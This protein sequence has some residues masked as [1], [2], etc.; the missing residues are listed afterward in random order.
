MS[1]R[2]ALVLDLTADT[3]IADQLRK[4]SDL[5]ARL[6]ALSLPII[7]LTSAGTALKQTIAQAEKLGAEKV[8][9]VSGDQVFLDPSVVENGL[10]RFASQPWDYLTQWEHVRLPVGVGFRA[11]A[12]SLLKR[13]EADGIDGF[14]QMAQWLGHNRM[15]VVA[16][17]DDHTYVPF[18]AS[19][20]D[21]R[22]RPALKDL[23]DADAHQGNWSLAGALALGRKAGAALTYARAPSGP[24]PAAVDGRGMP[25]LYGFESDDCG[26]FPTY[27]MLDITNRC[28]AACI[29]CPQ[30]VGFPG[31][32]NTTF[33]SLE[34]IKA[35]LDECEGRPVDFLRI[36]ADGEP[37]LHPGIYDIIAMATRT[38]IKSVGLTTNG[39]A[40]N[41]ANSA[42]LL[43]AG[44][45]VVDVS[46]DAASPESFAK[47]RVGLSYERTIENLKT[48]IRMRDE[49][50]HPLKIMVSFVKQPD[51]AHEEDAF[52]KMW[53]P[54]VD[55][56]LFRDFH[57]NVN[58]TPE[59]KAEAEAA[60]TFRW[61]CPHVFRRTVLGYDDGLKFCP[62]DWRGGSVL[63]QYGTE[64]LEAFWQGDAYHALRMV[65]L[66]N[67][68]SKDSYCGPC[69]DW[70]ATPWSLGYEKVISRLRA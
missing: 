65:H 64:P 13:A 24:Q 46:L 20:T 39:S 22:A 54:V 38:N 56:V 42:R 67:S 45:H 47:I 57:T 23:V 43:D 59:A 8:V 28:N 6:A 53:E 40:M 63:Q 34:K 21:T 19:L 9:V 69:G 11:Y 62:I 5:E 17:Y 27:V 48:L 37:L 4:A 32:E 36:T 44:L 33:A 30:S 7:R 61:P 31:M 3:P 15:T 26:T 58:A 35:L 60:E 29:H 2:L 66:N 55:M 12:V 52:R 1:Q 68:F 41:E 10:A 16:R 18:R 14:A 51:N 70:K 50:K 25:A 49:R